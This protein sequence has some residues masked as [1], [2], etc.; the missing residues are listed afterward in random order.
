MDV[1]LKRVYEPAAPG[2]GV[3]VLIDR[4]WPRGVSKERASLDRWAKDVAP[5]PAL[6]SAW[7]G[8]PRGHEPERFAAFAA[9][10]RDELAVDPAR[11]ALADLVEL[12]RAEPR[13][14]L[15]YGARDPDSNHATVLRDALLELAAQ[16]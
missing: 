10:Y 11:A 2:D 3:R 8:D 13:L 12:A 15:L 16:R 6:R 4:L 9:S 14:T 5:S 7:H 1:Q